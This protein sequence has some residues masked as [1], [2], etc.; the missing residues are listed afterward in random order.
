VTVEEWLEQYRRAWEQADVE[1]TVSLFTED[2]GYDSHPFREPH[3]GS[4][5]IRA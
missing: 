2:A 5:A 4:E 3:I 1:T